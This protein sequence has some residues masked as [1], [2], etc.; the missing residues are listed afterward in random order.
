MTTPRA[1]RLR[2]GVFVVIAL[3]LLGALIVLFGS[4][5]TYFRTAKYFTVR[6]TEAPG[7][8]P[9]TPVRRSG[10][11]IGAVRQVILDDERGIVRVQLAIDPQYTLRHN[12]IATLS[13][14]L[15][16]GDAS[17]DFIPQP[18]EEGRPVDRSEIQPGAELVGILAASVNTLLNRASEVVPTTQETLDQMRKS[19]QRLERLAPLAEDTLR[20]Y[21]DLAR[22]SRGMIPDLK[23]TNTEVQNLARDARAA[24]PDLRNAANDVGA[25]SRN[26]GRLSE[27]LDVFWQTN[28]DKIVKAIDNANEVLKGMVKAVDSANEAIN[29]VLN[30]LSDENQRAVTAI[31]KNTR[32]AS[33]RFDDL[34]RTLGDT[35]TKMD[36]VLADTQKLTGP[37]GERSERMV[38]NI[39]E[40][41]DSTRKIAAPLADRAE[42]IARNLDAVLATLQKILAPFSERSERLARD[43]EGSLDRLNRTLAD[44]DALMRVV[45]QADGTL[46]R[47]LTD[48]SLYIHLDEVVLAVG[49]LT[50]RIDR[51]LKDFETFADKLA[52]H[53]EAI[54]LGGVVRP[55]SGLKEPP[56]APPSHGVPP[57]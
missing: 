46:R 8:S 40:T 28:Q 10:V 14:S 55:G 25:A 50:P 53:P 48:P 56:T 15:L 1:L 6:F 57:P 39:D 52:R 21:R 26:V 24:L 19:L 29:R 33:D 30:L 3:I 13:T 43:L 31:L 23:K 5:P 32:R 41:L 9:G 38:R 12:E 51:I 44:V 2:L 27:R 16:G 36:K 35:L 42:P 7:V 37:L 22:E 20:E 17:I 34:T 11:R 49:H 4:L 18:P 54:G 47:F 45:D